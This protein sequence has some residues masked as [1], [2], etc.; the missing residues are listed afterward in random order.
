MTRTNILKR[1]REKELRE[2]KDEEARR[3]KIRKERIRKR[4]FP[5]DDLQLISEDLELELPSSPIGVNIL[6]DLPVAFHSFPSSVVDDV[7]Q[8]FHFLHGD[9]GY[10]KLAKFGNET[11]AQSTPEFSA[12]QL[13]S[14]LDE[15]QNGNAQR[16]RCIPPLLSHVFTMLLRVLMTVDDT[17]AAGSGVKDGSVSEDIE[18]SEDGA[19]DGI[20]HK[21]NIQDDLE[22]LESCLTPASWSEVLRHYMNLMDRVAIDKFSTGLMSDENDVEGGFWSFEGYLGSQQSQLH[23]ACSKLSSM[24]A[25]NLNVEDVATLLR[26][27]CD[28]VLSSRSYLSSE[29][30]KRYASFDIMCLMFNFYGPRLLN[31]I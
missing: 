13:A 6:P 2:E 3:E 19:S 27:L 22:K 15:I 29:V 4:R 11:V 20:I 24:D 5:M 8:I 16:A 9:L 1:S 23:R 12:V 28:D 21:Y 30:A 26:T 7:L 10:C 14:A 18:A 31:C 17:G 25:W